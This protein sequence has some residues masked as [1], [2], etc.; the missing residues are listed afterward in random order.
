MPIYLWDKAGIKIT[1]QYPIDAN[2][3]LSTGLYS[4]VDPATIKKEEPEEP[5][6]AKST[7]VKEETEIP[8]MENFGK[9]SK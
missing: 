4:R 9:K 2:E 5:K 7:R 8:G 1:F 6:A 3:A